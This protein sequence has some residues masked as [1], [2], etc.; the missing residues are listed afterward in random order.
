MVEVIQYLFPYLYQIEL[1]IRLTELGN[2]FE[3]M[4]AEVAAL[5]A[6]GQGI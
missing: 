4:D 5:Q 2:R 6:A 3:D 1:N